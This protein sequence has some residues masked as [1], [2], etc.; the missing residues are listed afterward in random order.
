ML[1]LAYGGLFLLR[2]KTELR[3]VISSLL[4]VAGFAGA[5]QATMTTDVCSFWPLIGLLALQNYWAIRMGTMKQWIT[6]GVATSVACGLL[7]SPI[8]IPLAW[9]AG[10]QTMLAYCLIIGLTFTGLQAVWLRLVAIGFMIVCSTAI[11]V[12]A[13]VNLADGW[14]AVSYIASL[15]VVAVIAWSV[16]RWPLLARTPLLLT[17]LL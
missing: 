3:W 10:F 5:D 12:G 8:E 17:P 14:Q 7:I 11:T 9:F 6:A 15:Q 16:Y 13:F 2:D 1:L 4:L